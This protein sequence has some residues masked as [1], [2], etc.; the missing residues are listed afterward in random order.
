MDDFVPTRLAG[1]KQAFQEL[2]AVKREFHPDDCVGV[3]AFDSGAEIVCPLT[4]IQT[5]SRILEQKVNDLETEYYT[6]ITAGLKKAELVLTR[7]SFEVSRAIRRSLSWISKALFETARPP[8]P[9]KN[10]TRRIL[11]LGDG[12]HNHGPM[13]NTVSDRLKRDGIVIDVIGISGNQTSQMQFDEKQLKRIASRSPDGTVRYCFICDT[14]DLIKTFGNLA[15]HIRP[16]AAR[17]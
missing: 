4:P 15:H 13:P 8:S 3:V 2:L 1:A 6:N 10:R 14:A 7:E 12:A 16:L 11:L 5:G 17:A 9:D